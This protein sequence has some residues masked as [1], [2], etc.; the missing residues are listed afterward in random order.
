MLRLFRHLEG[1]DVCSKCGIEF[2]AR[3]FN[4][5]NL[6]GRCMKGK[7]VDTKSLARKASKP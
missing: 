1:V 2:L 3:K 5:P 7:D 4:L 6:C